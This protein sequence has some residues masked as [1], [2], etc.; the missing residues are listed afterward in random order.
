LSGSGQSRTADPDNL[1]N[2]KPPPR[3][4]FLKW[5]RKTH[6]WIGLWGATLGLLFGVTG[7]LQNHR[8]ILKIPAA[9]TQESSVQ[10]ALPRATPIP[11][12]AQALADWL[13]QQLS[14]DRP[15]T[16]V[17][18]EPARPVPWGE[19]IMQQ[20]ARWT[21]AFTTPELNLQTEYWVGNSYVTIK[22]TDSNLF[23]TL[24]NLHK[25]TG[26]GVAWI[27]LADTLAGSIILLSLSGVLLWTLL[28]RRRMV[29][30]II[31]VISLTA[32]MVFA[33]QTM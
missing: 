22:R 21:A 26:A 5:L 13:Q 30:A 2:A 20:P 19:Q 33:L 27:L 4:L 29:G 15:A 16:K 32:A 25:G 3:G 6:G 12:N 14:F 17:K 10:L 23:A 11:A 24:N 18:T 31:G 28:H 7:I 1:N 9:Q 8:A